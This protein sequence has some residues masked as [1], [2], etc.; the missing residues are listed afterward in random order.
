MDE[1]NEEMIEEELLIQEERLRPR[2]I[3]LEAFT[4]TIGEICQ[5]PA[6]T[7]DEAGTIGQ[8]I[9]SMRHRGVGNVV[10]TRGGKLHGILTERDLMMKVAGKPESVT[11]RPVT[12]VMTPGPEWLMKKDTIAFLLNKMYVGGYRHM[13]ILDEDMRPIHTVSLRYILQYIISYLPDE[14][15][16][17]P[18]DPFRGPPTRDGG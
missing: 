12:E 3:N 18:P 10:I 14:V 9:Q 15:T 16:K 5:K 1:P 6:N 2:E 11:A 17:L 13:P 7:M 8:A 4:R